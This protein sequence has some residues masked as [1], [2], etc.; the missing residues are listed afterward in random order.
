MIASTCALSQ[1]PPK[2]SQE[3]AKPSSWKAPVAS[4]VAAMPSS[5][6]TPSGSASAAS[7][8]TPAPMPPIRM[9]TSGK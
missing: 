6:A 8:V 4:I 1:P 3:S 2:P 5:T 9:P 7:S